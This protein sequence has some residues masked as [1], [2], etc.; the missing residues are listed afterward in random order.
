M[1]LYPFLL[2]IMILLQEREPFIMVRASKSN[3]MTVVEEASSCSQLRSLS[4]RGYSIVQMLLCY[5]QKAEDLAVY[6]Y[7]VVDIPIVHALFVNT[8]DELNMR[9]FQR[10]ELKSETRSLTEIKTLTRVLDLPAGYEALR[11]LVVV[12]CGLLRLSINGPLPNLDTLDVTDNSLR[13]LPE[14][15]MRCTQLT[16][17]RCSKNAL[18]RLPKNFELLAQLEVLEFSHNYVRRL[19]TT[20]VNCTRLKVL[21]CDHNELVELPVD[22]GI[23]TELEELSISRNKISNMP[24]SIATL[25]KLKLVSFRLNPLLNVPPDFPEEATVLREY[26]RYLQEDPVPNKSIKLVLVGQ[27][28]V[29]K[30]TLL[31]AIKRTFWFVPNKANTKKTNGIEVRDIVFDDITLH[32]FDC[33]GDVD[34]TETHNFF[35]TPDAVYLVCFDL[36]EYLRATV[37]R[38]SFLLGRLQVWLHYIYCKVPSA[39]IIIVGTHVDYPG[40]TQTILAEIWLKIRSMLSLARPHHRQSFRSK[41]RLSNCLLCQPEAKAIRRLSNSS[42][43]AVGFVNTG[44]TESLESE[45]SMIDDEGINSSFLN[46][47][48]VHAFPHIIGYYEI[49]S[50]KS[51]GNGSTLPSN[52]NQSLVY[53]KDA[54]LEQAKLLIE[55]NPE[56]PRRWAYVHKALQTRLANN[57]SLR[58]ISLQEVTAIAASQNIREQEMINML[59]FFRSQGYLLYFPQV[60][61]LEDIVVLDPAW[62][63]QIFALVVSHKNFNMTSEGF[64]ER[65]R[66]LESLRVVDSEDNISR[67]QILGLLHQFGVCLQV[68]ENRLEFI[69]SRL[70]YGEP[71]DDIWHFLPEPGEKQLTYWFIFPITVPPPF[72]SQL[73]V[74]IYRRRASMAECPSLPSQYFANHVVDTL[75]VKCEGCDRCRTSSTQV[76]SEDLKVFHRIHVEFLP[77]R[78]VIACTVR[79][80]RPCCMMKKMK[81]I[82][83]NVVQSQFEGLNMTGKVQTVA[84][85]PV[86]TMQQYN[87]PHRIELPEEAASSS[88][89]KSKKITCI[90]GHNLPDGLEGILSGKIVPSY[91][92]IAMKVMDTSRCGDYTSCPKMFVLLPISMS[93]HQSGLQISGSLIDGYAIH[94]LC[95]IPDG[96]HFVSNAPGY[97]IKD[98]EKF[99]QNYGLHICRVLKVIKLI[100]G[101]TVSA[102]YADQTQTVA[103]N[104]DNLLASYAKSFPFLT[105][106]KQQYSYESQEYLAQMISNNTIKRHELRQL[107]HVVDKPDKFGQLRRLRMSSQTMW[108]CEEHFEQIGHVHFIQ[109]SSSKLKNE[110][111]I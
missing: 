98:P 97:R 96:Y 39:R 47:E 99:M 15:L 53:L 42:S 69:P 13:E 41:H 6:L 58:I 71:T 94:L 18:R 68:T 80:A 21:K 16:I 108:L 60:K 28:G 26:L 95:E 59:S 22:M 46:N 102:Q 48:N 34:F 40:L 65:S 72:I 67:L 86:C 64:I 29:G 101:S 78:N 110:K 83:E 36:S 63:A 20:I 14:A 50:V 17:L 90:N 74:A 10:F 45:S 30:S 81:K 51:S 25:Q 24:S 88:T 9:N 37:E 56:I 19:P 103:H 43:S 92:N 62:L 8:I 5:R 75:S 35:L 54:I 91:L 106:L 7:S 2:S 100:A 33:G 23:F 38:D 105:D 111:L 66:L 109:Q 104:V 44:Y 57:Y 70:P 89:G 4:K 82:I 77:R 31:K 85:C 12:S 61:D 49:S 1:I 79:G 3:H 76:K 27:E 32:C 11:S 93:L 52:A 55:K 107:L 73:I 84:I 87:N